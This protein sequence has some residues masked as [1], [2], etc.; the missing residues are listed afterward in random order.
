MLFENEQSNYRPSL[1]F[2]DTFE[3]LLDSDQN[4]RHWLVKIRRFIEHLEAPHRGD[5]PFSSVAQCVRTNK[6]GEWIDVL[7]K[8]FLLK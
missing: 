7:V 5:S 6:R 4:Q 2:Q 1:I 3:K 8:L